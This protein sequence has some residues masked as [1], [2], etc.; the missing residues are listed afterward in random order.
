M[1]FVVEQQ[2]Q[3]GPIGVP[4]DVSGSESMSPFINQSFSDVVVASNEPYSSDISF[5][6]EV[7]DTLETGRRN[8]KSGYG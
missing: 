3:R 7:S 8:C 4:I 6:E 1:V 5:G 2:Q